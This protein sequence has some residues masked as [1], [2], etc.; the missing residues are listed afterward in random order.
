MMLNL[1]SVLCAIGALLGGSSTILADE[2]LKAPF[3]GNCFFFNMSSF[4]FLTKII[5]PVS[6]RDKNNT[7]RCGGALITKRAVLTSSEC[8]RE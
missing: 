4:L 8:V 7:H 2:S 1:V 3:M 5:T 6:I